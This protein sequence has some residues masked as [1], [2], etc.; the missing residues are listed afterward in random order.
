MRNSKSD[1]EKER[2]YRA[3]KSV[4]ERERARDHQFPLHC[5]Q[6]L[7]AV[8]WLLGVLRLFPQ[9]HSSKNMGNVPS[10]EGG[11]EGMEGINLGLE[12]LNLGGPWSVPDISVFGGPSNKDG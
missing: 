8:A 6:L 1:R 3:R 12:G 5:I 11:E 4:T 2:Y 7:L 9:E 10:S